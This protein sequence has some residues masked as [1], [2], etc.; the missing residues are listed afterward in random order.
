MTTL[1]RLM[2]TV[3]VFG[4]LAF[5]QTIHYKV[6]APTGAL[7]QANAR[8]GTRGPRD[9]R[10]VESPVQFGESHLVVEFAGVPTDAQIAGLR[11]RGARVLQAMPDNAVLISS[12]RALDLSGLGVV[13]AEALPPAVKVSPLTE[14]TDDLVVEFHPDVDMNQARGI[15]LSAGLDLHENPDIG[16]HRLLVRRVNTRARASD[17][18]R[19]IAAR[20]EV[21]YV[22][23]ASEDLVT[24]RPVIPCAGAVTNG[25]T[26]AQYIATVG[27]GWDGAG[28]GSAALKYFWGNPTVKLPPAQAWGEIVRAMNEWSKVASVSW[29]QGTSAAGAKT[30]AV[31]FGTGNHGD[32]YPFDGPGNVLAHTFYPANPE[33]IAGDMHL[34]DAESW[35]IGANIDLYSVALHELGHALGLG[36]SDDPNAVMYPYYRMATTLQADDRKAILTLYAVST[37]TATP[38]PTPA[39]APPTPAP[40][41]TPAPAPA[42]TPNDRTAP[43]LTISNP[44]TTTST[45]TIATRAISGTVYDLGGVASVTWV[46]SLGGAGTAAGT[47]NWSANIPLQYGLNYI[48]VRATDRTGN[49]SWR[50]ILITRR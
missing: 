12:A 31:L 27:N 32:G 20:D 23:P 34:D 44:S 37:G 25:G 40:V 33:P 18:V 14:A 9:I 47:S 15:V 5:S 39:P 29:S 43:T 26:V 10:R 45:V 6:P 35:R 49:Y 28:L 36:H 41:P 11:A 42:P 21:A 7:D 8:E 30:I 3:L 16:D 22:F 2:V 13:S 24:G 50:T 46:N 38:V 1:N 4:T 19:A 48:T 17:V